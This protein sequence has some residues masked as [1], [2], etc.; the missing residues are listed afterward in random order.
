MRTPRFHIALGFCAALAGTTD[1][2]AD[3]G[4]YG[5]IK[6]KTLATIADGDFTAATYSN[7]ELAPM[8]GREDVL[9]VMR[10]G[11]ERPVFGSIGVSNSVTATPEVLALSLDGRFAYVIE[12][13][14]Q[15]AAGMKVISDLPAG[16]R[17]SIID[18][19]HPTSPKL[20]DTIELTVLPESLR[21]SPDGRFLA[22]PSNSPQDAVVQI[23]PV[24]N[25]KGGPVQ[26][27]K[28]DALGIERAPGN[29]PR[30]G[31]TAT[32]VDWH[33]SGRA[34]S[35]NLNTR[36]QV[37]FFK[38][39]AAV[40]GQVAL[41]PWGKPVAV[42]PDPF[43]GRF[44]PDGGHYITA[45]WGRN[46]QA[47]TTEERLPQQRSAVSVVK[48]APLD[49]GAS[50]AHA[51]IGGAPTDRSSE[52]LAISPDGR[53]IATVNM[54]ETAVPK[55]SP[56]F[57]KMASITLLSFDPATGAVSNAAT[58]PFEGILPEGATFDATGDHLLATVYEYYDSARPAGGI[59]V[60]KVIRGAQA[61]LEHLGR[62]ETPHGTH[63]VE[64]RN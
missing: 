53:W 8:D 34:I 9:T 54:R 30:G 60:F 36:N 41:E 38:V 3:P 21:V 7:S 32:F 63:H 52:G 1:A 26:T 18:I 48:L 4:L 27:F 37:A 33:P 19:S 5:L 39:N 25:G 62:I 28:L 10:L 16:K 55:T 31:I 15:R 47:K 57:T 43:V 17:L 2:L 45:D 58:V 11:T 59:E 42:G 6:G 64:I 46:F 44:T 23:I 13:L 51:R 50:V 20:S 14:G 24:A 12:R 35:V 29:A 40:G 56:R 22:V 49:A 61:R